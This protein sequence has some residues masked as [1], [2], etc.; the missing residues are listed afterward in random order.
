MQIIT[1]LE[2]MD[3]SQESQKSSKEDH[4]T[5]I[6]PSTIFSAMYLNASGHSLA[7]LQTQVKSNETNY[8]GLP[9]LFVI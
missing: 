2:Q 7:H 4:S 6:L 9:K 3:V 8:H 5:L 1:M